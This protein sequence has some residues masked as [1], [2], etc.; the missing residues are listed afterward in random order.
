MLVIRID[1]ALMYEEIGVIPSTV[2][3]LKLLPGFDVLLSKA[4]AETILDVKERGHVTLGV[5]GKVPEGDESKGHAGGNPQGDLV[6]AGHDAG[7][8]PHKVVEVEPDFI[9]G[10]GRITM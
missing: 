6:L 8:R 9:D 3:D 1:K 2:K 4:F 10:E 7:H 5:V